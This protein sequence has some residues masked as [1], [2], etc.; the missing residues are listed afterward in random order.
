[1][2]SEDLYRYLPAPLQNAVCSVH[3][4]RVNRTRF[5]PNFWELLTAAEEKLTWSHDR[6]CAFRD[7]EL[8]RFVQH[9]YD[10]VP[11]YRALFSRLD[12]SPQSIATLDDLQR[13][14][15]LTKAEVQ[16]ASES[17]VSAAVPRGQRV[18]AHTS[19]TTGGGLRFVS[20][21]DAVQRQWAVWWRYRRLHGLPFGTWCGYFGGRSVV[22]VS[23]KRPPFWRHNSPGKQILF[24]GYHIAPKTAPYYIEELRRRQPPWL[25]GYPSLLALIARFVID[26]GADLGYR[27]RWITVGAENVLP[28]QAKTIEAAFGVRPLSHYGMAEAV[29]NCFQC[30]HGRLH[31]DEDFAATEFVPTG[32]GSTYRIVGSNITNPAMPFLRYDVGDMARLDNGGCDCG[33]PGRIVTSI[34]GRHE[35][36][37]VLRNH[38]RL[39]RLDHIFKDLVQIREAQ[40]YQDT[41]GVI[42]VRVVRN[43]SYGPADERQ[44]L[45]EFRKRVGAEAEVRIEYLDAL[46]R[47]TSGKLRFV[48]SDIEEGKLSS[49]VSSLPHADGER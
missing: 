18:M 24:S 19:G 8:R 14:P 3:G 2:N 20:T 25:H 44:L 16:G 30:R 33:L 21:I 15:I 46:A 47:T 7:E 22:P 49:P 32:D 26:G 48:I 23:Q 36:Y 43:P 35:D 12:I 31:V 39:G 4:W 38:V 9:C 27:P 11:Y 42:I 5:G 45:A 41:P 34:D 37:V 28:Q 29:A 13:L 17:F 6:L 10:T 1:M 40:I